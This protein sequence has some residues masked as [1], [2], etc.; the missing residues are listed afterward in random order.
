MRRIRAQVPLGT[1]QHITIVVRL[2]VMRINVQSIVR[3]LELRRHRFHR[4]HTARPAT[5][6]RHAITPV[7]H[8]AGGA[9]I[10]CRI[11]NALAALQR[12]LAYVEN[13]RI[14]RPG[15]NISRIVA[16]VLRPAAHRVVQ[17][18]RA[19][20]G[21]RRERLVAAALDV[22]HHRLRGGIVAHVILLAVVRIG[23]DALRRARKIAHIAERMTWA[24]LVAAAATRHIAV[25]TLVRVAR[26]HRHRHPGAVHHHASR[27]Q[28]A[29]LADQAAGGALVAAGRLARADRRMASARRRC[30]FDRVDDAVRLAGVPAMLQLFG[31]PDSVVVGRAC[32]NRLM[33][34]RRP[35]RRRWIELAAK[36][37]FGVAIGDVKQGNEQL[38]EDM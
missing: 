15:G 3:T 32:A 26:L 9:P 29:V 23:E 22:R 27:H 7:E 8:L 11:Q 14:A 28:F 13:I 1:H 35:L 2:T 34:P 30:D 25:V 36:R 38:S 24:G 37:A 10:Q 20:A 4:C 21:G 19:V 31:N 5:S 12:R 6:S 17:A 18:H 16:R 33:V